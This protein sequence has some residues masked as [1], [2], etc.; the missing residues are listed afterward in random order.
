MEKRVSFWMILIC[1]FISHISSSQTLDKDSIVASDNY[2][3]T[4]T[5]SGKVRGYTHNGTYIF[6]GIPYAYSKRF[7]P[8]QKMDYW[9]DDYARPTICYGGVCPIE[10]FAWVNDDFEFAFQ[11]NWGYS[12]EN[13]QSLNIWTQGL[14]DGKKRPVMVWLHGGGF[15]TGSSIELPSYDG[16]NLSKKGDVVLG[17]INHRL[18]VLGFLDM[19]AYGDKYKGS[20]NAGLLDIVAALQWVKDNIAQFGGDPDNVTIFG[21]S[22]GGGK[23][24]CMMSSP[25]AKGLFAKAIVESGSYVTDFTNKIISQEITATLLDTLHIQ[26]SQADS[27][28]NIPY[29]ILNEAANKAYQKVAAG[30][31]AKGKKLRGWGPTLDGNLLPYQPYDP[32][33]ME[34]SS[35][36]PLLIGTTKNEFTVFDTN[37]QNPTMEKLQRN[38][39]RFYGDSVQQYM[40]AVK[41]AYPST[42]KPCDYVNIEINFRKLAIEQANE[43][44]KSGK[45]PVY[46][47]LFTWQSPVNNGLYKAMHCMDI[48]F[49]FNNISRCKE[50][51]GGG[52]DAIQLADKVSSAWLQFAKTGNPNTPS[53]PP[54]PAY[55]DENGA[56]MML[57]SKCIIRNHPDADLLKIAKPFDF[58]D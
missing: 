3:V 33:A 44:Y 2:A 28:Q 11:H 8:P 37:F 14:H 9:Y 40:D 29:Q 5:E 47:Y 21:Q 51:T 27:L 18:N 10:S 25:S 1:C 20:A 53:L 4:S 56:T 7:M 55:T 12:R 19:S 39:K 43:K 38:L 34:L 6:K 49:Q 45:A 57:D 31:M 15:S 30:Y 58:L 26:P 13:C 17:S 42:T 36:V 52:K 35:D 23:V 24:T 50:M 16:E 48:A 46:M 32:N 54:W 22:G 41:K